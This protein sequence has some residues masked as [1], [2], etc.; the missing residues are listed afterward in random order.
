MP[1]EPVYER[2][3]ALCAGLP[4]TPDTQSACPEQQ[5]KGGIT[6][7]SAATAVDPLRNTGLPKEVRNPLAVTLCQYEHL[8]TKSS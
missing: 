8:V 7:W 4:D 3:S 1:A 2:R 6:F 5:G